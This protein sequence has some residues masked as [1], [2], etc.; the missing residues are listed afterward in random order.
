ML[1]RN[2]IKISKINFNKKKTN[3]YIKH[4]DKKMEFYI[5]DTINIFPISNYNKK[6]NLVIKIDDETK[7]L[8]KNIEN[9]FIEENKIERKNYIP[10]IKE[11]DK[12]NII[13]LKILYRYEKLV[14]ECFNKNKEHIFYKDIDKHTKMDCLINICNFW[15]Y[16][17]KYGMIIYLTKIITK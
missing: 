1:D 2:L 8:I 13:K 12:G 4:D 9:K 16:N 6:Y 14:L 3:Y 5:R 15:N 10:I 11:N 17:N 7:E